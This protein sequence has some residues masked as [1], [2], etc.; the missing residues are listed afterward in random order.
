MGWW[1]VPEFDSRSIHCLPTEAV[2][3]ERLQRNS[4]VGRNSMEP[5]SVL[6]FERL[7]DFLKLDF[8]CCLGDFLF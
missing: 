7:A 1:Q 4:E 2:A 6:K 3:Q 5:L 8:T